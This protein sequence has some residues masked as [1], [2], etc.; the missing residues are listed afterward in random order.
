[1]AGM[2]LM[3]YDAMALGPKELSLG[4]D[5]LQK[6]MAEARFPMLSANA[7][8]AGTEQ[9]VAQPYA[10]FDVGGHRVGIIGLTRLP[11][12]AL[13]GFE[14]LDPEQAVA[15]YLPEVT[16]QAETVVLLTNAGYRQAMEFARAVPGIDLVVAGL[17]DQLPRQ[18]VRVPETGT[19]MLAAEQPVA[20]HTGRR[21]GKLMVTLGSDGSL[22][23][24]SWQSV[25]MDASFADDLDMKVLLD[26]YRQ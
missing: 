21:V 18:A 13:P 19:I 10:V 11:D 22:S 14:V 23:G 5:I 6:R 16:K 25:P 17:P 2:N 7:V 4:L 26:R 12:L 8:Q 24:E 1:V 9:L 3:G 15:R 20:K